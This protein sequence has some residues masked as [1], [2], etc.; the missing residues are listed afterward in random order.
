MPSGAIFSRWKA[1]GCPLAV[2]FAHTQ[3]SEGIFAASQRRLIF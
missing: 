1:L 2:A 3:P